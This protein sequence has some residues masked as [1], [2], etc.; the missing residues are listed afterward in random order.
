VI[1]YWDIQYTILS[2]TIESLPV[3]LG[4]TNFNIK[5]FYILITWK[6]CVL[7]GS[8]SKQ[9]ILPYTTLKGCFFITDVESVYCE[10][11]TESS[12]NADTSRL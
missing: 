6:M 5:N 12:Y 9:Q 7:Y 1:Y 4:T 8:R 10:A 3:T 11:R 2:L